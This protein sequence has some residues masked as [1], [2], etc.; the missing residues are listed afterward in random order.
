MGIDLGLTDF[1]A[2]GAGQTIPNPKYGK[3]SAKR[4]A[5]AQRRLAAQKA[6]TKVREKKKKV[7]AKTYKRVVYQRTD[8]FHKIANDLVGEYGFIFA[9]DLKP[10]EMLSYR[11]INRY[12]L[13]H[14]MGVVSFYS[15]EQSGRGWPR[16][17][18]GKTRLYVPN[19]FGVQAPPENAVICSDIFL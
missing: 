3:H 17:P 12:P 9:E 13:R 14:R 18:E 16:V 7:V 11:A 8:F 2:T 5:Q 19:L 15:L 4:L 1:L 6:G 10:S